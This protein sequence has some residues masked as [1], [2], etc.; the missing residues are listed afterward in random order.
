MV[1]FLPMFLTG[2]H[3]F[4]LIIRT[5]MRL[6]ASSDDKLTLKGPQAFEEQESELDCR[7]L[8]KHEQELKS[9]IIRP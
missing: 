5:S 8:I 6:D 9:T 4:R 2:L 1:L 3:S 7:G